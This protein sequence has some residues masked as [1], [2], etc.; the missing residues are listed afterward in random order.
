M[1]NY[2]TFDKDFVATRAA[3]FRDQVRRRIEGSLTEDEFKPLRLMNGLYL[4][5][6]AYMLRVA[7][8]Y[9][10]LNSRQMQA[11]ADIADRW[12]KGYAHFSTRQNVQFHWPKLPDVPDI[13]AA[14]AAV[15]MHAIQTSGACIRSVNSPAATEPAIAFRN[16]GRV[17]LIVLSQ[18]FT[19]PP[20]LMP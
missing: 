14:L 7:I 8:P 9:G 19:F 20:L 18:L 15:E 17:I 6:H 3:Q 16:V 4:L 10:T 12:D 2:T 1:Y 5:L 11:L 13:L